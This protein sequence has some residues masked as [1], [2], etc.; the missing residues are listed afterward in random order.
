MFMVIYTQFQD[1]SQ[2]KQRT[3]IVVAASV[4]ATLLMTVIILVHLLVKTGM[5]NYRQTIFLQSFLF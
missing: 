5:C 2:L 4:V 1:I 3:I